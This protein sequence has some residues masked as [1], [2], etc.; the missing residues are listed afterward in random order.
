M[1]I[2][3][4][5]WLEGVWES[6]MGQGVFVETWTKID[7]RTLEGEGRMLVNDNV[8]MHELLQIERIH[9]HV[10]YIAIVGKQNP[11]LFTLIS[12]DD[13]TWVFENPEH[14]FPQRISYTRV[15]KNTIHARVSGLKQGQQTES[16]YELKRK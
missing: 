11:T 14:D 2:E 13:N 5:F 12:A 16:T 9:D 8:V 15:D 4:L 3:N 7:D 10:A 1:S 6:N